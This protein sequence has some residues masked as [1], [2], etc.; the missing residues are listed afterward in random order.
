MRYGENAPTVLANVESFFHRLRR[1]LSRGEWAVRR[2]GLSI[3][4]DSSEEP[5]LL[6]IQID[7]LSRSL[8][9]SP[10]TQDRLPY[11]HRLR[12]RENHAVHAFETRGLSKTGVQEEFFWGPAKSPSGEIP[13][14][15]DGLLRG[16]SS[17]GGDCSGG[18]DPEEC[19]FAGSG[20][21]TDSQPPRQ[22]R[23]RALFPLLEFSDVL[24]ITTRFTWELLTRVD[25]PRPS[26][27]RRELLTA[28]T[29]IDLVR[30]LPVVHVR[31]SDLD[32]IT[33]RRGSA[34][35]PPGRSLRGID[36]VVRAL[37][38]E[39]HRAHR[40]DY[41][42]WIFSG[43]EE[44]RDNGFILLPP[45]TWLPGPAGTALCPAD[46]HQAAQAMLGRRAGKAPHSPSDSGRL[47]VISYNVHSC[48]GMD[49]RVSPR[50]IARVIARQHGDIVALQELDHGRAR[51]RAEDQ[52]GEI[53]AELGFHLLFC[54]TVEHG[55]ERYGHALLSRWPLEPIK[56]AALPSHL[57]GIW[58]EPR[59]A[60]WAR[61]HIA[62]EPIH[63]LSTHLGL[64][65]PER[66]KQMSALLG[67]EWLG[68]VLDREPVILCGD[69][70][71]TPG[72]PAHRLAA[73]R[74]RDVAHAFKRGI[75][76]FSSMRL[77][78]QLDHIFVSPHFALESVFAA[79]NDLTRRAS[80]HLPLVAHLRLPGK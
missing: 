38:I 24:R 65:A 39:A 67:S 5:G 32:E 69:F 46:L 48:I 12:V 37:A 64:A 40:R 52:A 42:V 16:G 41:Q 1:R 55:G 51:S 21:G 45:A 19:H 4:P 3:A 75:P 53:A 73:S 71:L 49:G 35:P 72:S 61:V 78:A 47:T 33:R 10:K 11:L 76:T 30:G 63:V 80:D 28:G 2:F 66:R 27:G 29:K 57:G 59:A 74:L 70:N 68:P 6:L 17:W 54:P 77:V 43:G 56:I 60:I 58:P 26:I 18:A 50:R 15:S 23:A 79:Q 14:T 34:P 25:D 44:G 20:S 31:F 9:E 8:L 13:A 36:N 62:D 22:S 7:G